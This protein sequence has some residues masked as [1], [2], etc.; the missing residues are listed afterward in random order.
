MRW[1]GHAAFEK[2]NAYSVLVGKPKRKRQLGRH[3]CRWENN[4]GWVIWTFT[5]FR[6]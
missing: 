2:R 6:I 3:R 1:A 5:L 4:T